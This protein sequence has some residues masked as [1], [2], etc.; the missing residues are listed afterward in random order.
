MANKD[1]DDAKYE[2]MIN[3][4]CKNNSELPYL[5]EFANSMFSAKQ[6][7]RTIY[8]YIVHI[9]NF[10]KQTNKPINEI[11]LDDYNAYIIK[12]KKQTSGSLIVKYSAINKFAQYLFATKKMQYN[13]MEYAKRPKYVEKQEQIQKRE[14]GYLTPNEIQMVIENIQRGIKNGKYI[15]AQD[16]YR[17]RDMSMVLMFLTTGMRTVALQN[18]DVDDLNLEE[19]IVI[20]TDKEDKVNIHQMPDD[21]VTVLKKWLIKREALLKEAGKEDETALFIS[22]RKQRISYDGIKAI[23]CKYCSN[24]TGKHITPHKLRATYG[25]MLYNKTHDIEFVRKQ[26]NHSNIATTQRYIRGTGKADREK[27]ANIMGDIISNRRE[28]ENLF[29]D[30]GDSNDKTES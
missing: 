25:T 29:E 13:F 9:I 11:T 28:T 24:I 15:W 1:R 6:S 5:T 2:E 21:T 14:V 22:N 26:M 19:G 8:Y 10:L 4:L 23:V 18:L 3:K 30:M 20:V 16:D 17:S 12:Y 27:A 7:N